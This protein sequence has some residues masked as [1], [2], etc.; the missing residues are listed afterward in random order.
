MS[1]SVIHGERHKDNV[2]VLEPR[3]RGIDFGRERFGRCPIALGLSSVQV[4]DLDLREI[5]FL[6]NCLDLFDTRR[7]RHSLMISELE[8]DSAT[9]CHPASDQGVI[10]DQQHDRNNMYVVG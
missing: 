6:E 7:E 4:E 5:R 1:P 8:L 9:W 10:L 2:G 3:Q